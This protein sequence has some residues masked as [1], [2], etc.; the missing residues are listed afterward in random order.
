MASVAAL[1]TPEVL[2]LATM[3]A[4]YR[5]TDDLPLRG[6]ARSASCGST[7]E[8]GIALDAAGRIARIGLAGQACAAIMAAQAPGRSQ[9]DFAQ[10]EAALVAWLAGQGDLPDWPGLESIAPARGFAGR[11]GAILLGWR[12]VREAFAAR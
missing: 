1:Y 12:A 7:L 6:R 3:L 11:H 9:Q 4:A 5:L 10:A 2:G 8:V